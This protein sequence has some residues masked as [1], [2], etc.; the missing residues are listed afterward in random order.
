MPAAYRLDFDDAN[1]ATPVA[2]ILP[3][4]M[5]VPVPANVPSPGPHEPRPLRYFGGSARRE[6]TWRIAPRRCAWLVAAW[7]LAVG[8]LFVP[9]CDMSSAADRSELAP[10]YVAY[11]LST[12]QIR[13]FADTTW[14]YAAGSRSSVPQAGGAAMSLACALFLVGSGVFVATPFLLRRRV[15]K[16]FGGVGWTVAALLLSPWAMPLIGA[17]NGSG[18]H[19]AEGYYLLSAAHS[20]AFLVLL[21]PGGKRLNAPPRASAAAA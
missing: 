5:S 7:V 2:G 6:S 3:L 17:A 20:M 1:E 14:D 4:Q 11:S 8:S 16:G 12:M 15:R 21:W 9:G 18:R 19:F 13:E 10:T